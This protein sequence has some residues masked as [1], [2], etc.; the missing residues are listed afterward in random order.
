MPLSVACAG[1]PLSHPFQEE[2]IAKLFSAIH[3]VHF[4]RRAE[5]P[6]FERK[7]RSAS[8]KAQNL[9]AAAF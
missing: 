2:V 5:R 9:P 1:K 4:L 8:L 6:G 3:F 7:S